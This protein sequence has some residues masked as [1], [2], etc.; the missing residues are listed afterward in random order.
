MS[1]RADPGT[2]G[3]GRISFESWF[4]RGLI[5]ARVDKNAKGDQKFPRCSDEPSM[6]SQSGCSQRWFPV[7]LLGPSIYS[8][9]SAWSVRL[10]D[11]VQCRLAK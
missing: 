9:S 3:A 1:A 8:V 7:F 5:T 11:R 4:E 6:A 2:S 10:L